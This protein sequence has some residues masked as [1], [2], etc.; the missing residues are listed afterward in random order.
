MTTN[1]CNAAILN[2]EVLHYLNQGNTLM[3]EVESMTTNR[4]LLADAAI[5]AG[6][7]YLIFAAPAYA[8]FDL[9]TGQYLLQLLAGLAV[10]VWISI[11]PIRQKL[12]VM[13]KKETKDSPTNRADSA[14][15][16]DDAS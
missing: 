12:S 7:W 3:G 4:I 9:G 11:L 1:G 13:F 6:I 8:Y 5:L 14:T 16:G 2:I 10:A 15:N